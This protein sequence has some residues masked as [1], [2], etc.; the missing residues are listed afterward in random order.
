MGESTVK[1]TGECSK[2]KKRLSNLD[3]ADFIA[4]NQIKPETELLAIAAMN[5][6]R[7]EEKTWPVLCYRAVRKALMTLSNKRGK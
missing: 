4:Q 2:I 7:R 1:N 6:E 5:K 3:V